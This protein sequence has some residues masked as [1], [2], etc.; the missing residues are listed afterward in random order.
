MTM[1]SEKTLM[2]F[3]RPLLMFE[4]ILRLFFQFVGFAA[5]AR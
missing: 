4:P 2:A 1:P 3:R 5:D